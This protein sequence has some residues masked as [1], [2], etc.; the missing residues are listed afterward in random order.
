MTIDPT[1]TL[2]PLS[3]RSMFWRPTYLNRSDWIEHLPFA[4]WLV[5]AQRP[6]VLVELGS[7][8]GVSYFGFCQAVDRLGLDT[9]CY[10]VDTWKGDEHAGLYGEEVFGKVRAHNNA[11]YSAFS[12]LIRSTFDEAT[13]HFSDGTIDF[14]HIDGL[15]TMEAVAHDFETWLPKLSPRAVVLFHDTNVRERHFGVFKLFERFRAEYP[16]FEFVHGNGLGV[17]GV[18]AEQPEL[19]MRL[20]AADHDPASRQALQEVFGRLGRVCA[21]QHDSGTRSDQIEK[22]RQ[23][24]VIAQQR[25]EAQRVDFAE[26]GRKLLLMEAK[27]NQLRAERATLS[28]ERRKLERA[29]LKLQ[30]RAA[31]QAGEIDLLK[32]AANKAR[33]ERNTAEI[34]REQIAARCA[35]LLSTCAEHLRGLTEVTSKLEQAQLRQAAAEHDRDQLRARVAEQDKEIATLR[36]RAGALFSVKNGLETGLTQ[37]F[38]E[39]ATLTRLLAERAS[40]MQIRVAQAEGLQAHLAEVRRGVAWRVTTPWR[41]LV[42]AI[43]ADRARIR[44]MVEESNLF[45]ADWYKK[46]NPDVI[47]TGID[48]L[49]HFLRFGGKEGRDPSERFSTSAYLRAYQ[50]VASAGT[51]ALVHYVLHGRIE[52]R[53]S[54]T[55]LCV[56]SGRR[57]P[58]G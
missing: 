22:L 15:H 56:S 54:F 34:D 9:R 27:Q 23:D 1:A 43:G 48:P 4:F 11:H 49:D 37:R 2:R 3:L 51:N 33:E 50:D 47:A 21:D 6:H 18:G 13:E 31:E 26:L 7:H 38:H 44:R 17:L 20:F 52:G 41:V 32:G 58:K 42:D 30:A 10:A 29:K 12:R 28:A 55:A 19:L 40:E 24:L 16:A 8:Y 25:A 53:N 36:Q 39:L 57:L 14:L 45:D 35:T 5:E 46:K